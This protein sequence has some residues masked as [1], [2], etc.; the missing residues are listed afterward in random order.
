VTPID[1]GIF[2]SR[3]DAVCEEMGAVLRNPQDAA[4]DFLAQIGVN[5]GGAARLG[6]VVAGFGAR[7]FAA[8]LDALNAHGERLARSALAEIPAGTYRFR[9]LMDDDGMVREL[10]P[11]AAATVT[12]LGERRIHRPWGLAG[13]SPGS[14]GRQLHNGRELP[15]KVTLEVAAGDRLRVE[16]PGGGGWG[17]GGT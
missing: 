3:L 9:D 5:R 14:A 10:Q 8:G 15:G 13:G 1:L 6:E 16:T 11:L 7:A 12:L 4:G 2:A 17:W